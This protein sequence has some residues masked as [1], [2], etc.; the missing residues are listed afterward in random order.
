MPRGE[1][2][3]SPSSPTARLLAASLADPLDELTFERLRAAALQ[4]HGSLARLEAELRAELAGGGEGTAHAQVLARVLVATDRWSEARTTLGQA[5]AHAMA[6]GS[7]LLLRA[8]LARKAGHTAD[9]REDLQALLALRPAANRAA[10]VEA[11]RALAELAL[12]A[13]VLAEARLQFAE[14]ARLGER[15]DAFAR[16][17][18]ARGLHGEAA[19]ELRTL[20]EGDATLAAD[21]GTLYLA[22]ARSELAAG[23]HDA[24]LATLAQAKGLHARSQRAEFSAL[25]REAMRAAGALD[26]LA[27]RLERDARGGRVAA[28]QEAAELYRELGDEARAR[29]CLEAWVARA[30]HEVRAR[31]ELAAALERSGESAAA[32]RA[33]RELHRLAPGQPAYLV[34]L[35]E[36]LHRAGKRE[37]ALKL[38][39]AAA[40]RAGRD[41]RLHE[42]LREL[43]LR[44]GEHSLAERALQRLVSLDPDNEAHAVALAEQ[45][46]AAGD[47]SAALDAF[48]RL[49][50]GAKDDARTEARLAR[51]L[52]EHDLL[53]E[54]IEHA[55]RAVALAGGGGETQRLLAGLLERAGRDAEAEAA[56]RAALEREGADDEA[57]R[58]ARQHIAVLLRRTG[59]LAQRTSEL[60]QSLRESPDDLESIR[61]LAELYARNPDK[62]RQRIALLDRLLARAPRDRETLLALQEAHL[63]RGDVAA[64]L[65]VAATRLSLE[66]PSETDVL[67]ALELARGR[68]RSEEALVLSMR[69]REA[70]AQSADVQRA[71]GDLFTARE[72]GELA[73]AAYARAVQL[74]ARQFAARYALAEQAIAGGD[75]ERAR[76]QLEAV[77]LGASDE[78]LVTSALDLLVMHSVDAAATLA[79]LARKAPQRAALRRAWLVRAVDPLLPSLVHAR[80]G[81]LA[82]PDARLR[83]IVRTESFLLLEALASEDRAERERALALFEIVP[84]RPALE[85]LLALAERDD[86]GVQERARALL[87][88]GLQADP[89]AAVR[90]RRLLQSEGRHLR[91]FALWSLAESAGPGAS[92]ELVAALAADEA[93]AVLAASVLGRAPVQEAVPALSRAATHG[94]PLLRV[95]AAWSLARAGTPPA[96]ALPP[97]SSARTLEATAALSL[98]S[99]DPAQ[100]AQ[101]LLGRDPA[102]RDDAMRVIGA[103]DRAKALRPWWPYDPLRYARAVMIGTSEPPALPSTALLAEVVLTRLS[104]G[105]GASRELELLEPV[106][107][108]IAPRAFGERGVCF[109]PARAAE[110]GV[111]LRERLAEL[112]QS[113]DSAVRLRALPLLVASGGVEHPALLAALASR[114]RALREAA[115]DALASVDAGERLSPAVRAAVARIFYRDEEWPSRMR[116]ARLLRHTL[117]PDQLAREPISLVRVA[118]PPPRPLGCAAPD[119]I[120]N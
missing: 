12:D 118:A 15:V 96:R 24:A 32:E 51:V 19:N 6:P 34:A 109:E 42:A 13:G 101:A 49:R 111:R 8:R 100:L 107:G 33:Y 9:A 38:L 99:G 35:A 113:R 52:G 74:D 65:R 106:P 23:R 59:K 60:E 25:E 5:I 70:G 92:S 97:S 72:E 54:A 4:E 103:S 105:E 63:E 22:L 90:L 75:L 91:P 82:E 87:A 68:P 37:E 39:A 29:A 17:L 55:E 64:S 28:W 44:W 94:A 14:L 115:L 16:A 48:G 117:T 80:E 89:S 43:Y 76:E 81:V 104:A 27:E 84:H 3:A 116:A 77:V 40:A 7:A 11:R 18:T 83:E 98:G 50:R 58:E 62:L 93:S 20:L 1:R 95:V 120:A 53:P 110:L 119:G 71:L 61:F 10:R 85:R 67:Q 46:L 69:A 26:A 47:R 66:P 31:A 79:K 56:W 41:A 88:V 45:A 86:A 108:G 36:L 73:R 57:R 78:A 114:E 30:P 112:A 2:A 21:R 102:L